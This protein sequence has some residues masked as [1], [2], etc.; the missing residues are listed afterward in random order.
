MC[1]QHLEESFLSIFKFRFGV[2]G[3]NE[4]EHRGTNFFKGHTQ[5]KKITLMT[6]N[7]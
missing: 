5:L 3:G 1:N 6:N 4:N 2:F 7:Y